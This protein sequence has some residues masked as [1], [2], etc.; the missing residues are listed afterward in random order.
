MVDRRTT[1]EQNTLRQLAYGIFFAAFVPLIFGGKIYNT[2]EKVM[3]TKT[4][5][6][7]SHLRRLAMF[8]VD[9]RVWVEFFRILQVRRSARC[10]RSA[11]HMVERTAGDLRVRQSGPDT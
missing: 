5:L 7:L 8:Y 3:V 9:W 10:R 4:V 1:P 11:G 2:V 6:V